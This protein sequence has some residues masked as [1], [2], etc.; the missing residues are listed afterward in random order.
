MVKVLTTS[1]SQMLST[2]DS[3][4][5]IS[6]MDGELLK[7]TMDL[8]LPFTKVTF[9]MEKN[10]ARV[11]MSML[12]II[13]TMGTGPLIKN[14]ERVFIIMQRDFTMV[15]GKKISNMDREH[16]NLMMGLNSKGPF[17]MISLFK[18]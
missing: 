14:R 1:M 5:I 11:S 16:S 3:S 7:K 15:S 13:I 18:D 4:T 9:S 6:S 10:M 8:S 2:Q 12:T 17:K